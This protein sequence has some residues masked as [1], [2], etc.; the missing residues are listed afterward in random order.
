MQQ[1]W[2]CGQCHSL[3]D[4]T[5]KRCYRCGAE[6]KAAEVVDS[7]GSPYAPGVAAVAPRDPS[8]FGAFVAGLI[9]AIV[10]TL[11]WYWWDAHAG[12]GLFRLSWL[13]GTA[14]A[15]AVTL[16]G[17]G[18]TSFPIV[19]ISVLLT[20]ASLVVGEYLI[21]SHD[22]YAAFGN[23]PPGIVLADPADVGRVIGGFVREVPV[24]PLLWL[25]AL[26]AA[27]LVPWSRLVG[28]AP[29]RRA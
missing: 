27:F 13:V 21:I 23:E 6:R 19:L 9:V 7:S 4:A 11:L 1:L 10:A 24:R 5:A 8:V 16:G 18:R 15:I 20:A 22:I 3:N 17:R 2:M 25:V 26:A 14:I 28:S 29:G 12:R